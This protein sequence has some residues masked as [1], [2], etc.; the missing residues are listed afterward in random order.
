MADEDSDIDTKSIIIPGM[1]D[2]I[3][4]N[5]ISLEYH[6]PN[7]EH[8]DAK[9]IRL[10]FNSFLK[11]N[12][13]FLELLYTDYYAIDSRGL[14]VCI[15]NDLCAMREE[16]SNCN[17]ANTFGACYGAIMRYYKLIISYPTEY[18]KQC[19]W[20]S[21]MIRY[22]EFMIRL[23][24]NMPFKDCFIPYDP[25]WLLMVKR[26]QD[27]AFAK[28]DDIICEANGIMDSAERHM[29]A[30]LILKDEDA[31][32]RMKIKLDDLAK[33][34]IKTYLEECSFGF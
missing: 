21:H 22:F 26:G 25:E 2:L 13:N 30:H 29:N 16:I 1:D 17:R 12:P 6:L 20:L 23:E 32:K 15:W 19:K 28:S 18:R 7:D 8:A 4:F 33:S 5:G 10:M 3:A 14:A 11:G 27:P 31:L 9:D 34:A 24:N